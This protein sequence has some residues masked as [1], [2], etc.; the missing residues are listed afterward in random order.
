[1]SLFDWRYAKQQGGSFILRLED[2]DQKRLIE[3]SIEKIYEAFEWYGLTPDEGPKQGGEY[4]PY[5]Q[6]ER[7]SIYQQHVEKLIEE[8]NAYYCFCSSERLDVMRAAQQAAKQPPRYDKKCVSIPLNEAKARIANG[9]SHVVR[10]NVPT[11]GTVVLHDLVRGDVTFRYDQV[12]DSVLLKSDGFPTYH[13]AVV[14][15]DHLMK[16]SHVLRGEEWLSSA[17]KHLLLYECFGWLPPMFAHLPLILGTDKKKL[18]KRMGA[19]SALSFRDEG[20][21]PEAMINFLALMGW[22]PKGDEE[23]LSRQQIIDQFNFEDINPS[24]A[25]FDRTKLDWMNGMYIRAMTPEK[26]LEAVN[27]FWHRPDDTV[28]NEWLLQAISLIHDR[29]VK[30]SDADELINFSFPTTWNTEVTTFDHQL[31]VPKKSSAEATTHHL[32]QTAKWLEQY[33]GEWDAE[34]LKEAM[35]T[36]IAS[37]GKKNGEIL[38]P[39]RV[40]LSLRAASPDVFD[41]LA[42]LGK[43]ESIRRITTIFALVKA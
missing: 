1:M 40:A 31:L 16:I 38:W 27:P 19:T 10:L 20:Y 8:G 9:E 4:G 22:H 30:L 33:V 25:I 5:V 12:D 2:T 34:M 15:D 28:T 42:L 26:L 18:S 39:L 7:L 36:A 23:I 32:E 6:S 29:L 37:M 17:P 24:G 35:I 13:L 14:V 41:L 43:E 11:S 3:G 21:L